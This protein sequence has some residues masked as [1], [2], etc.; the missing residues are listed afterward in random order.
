M[1]IFLVIILIICWFVVADLLLRA[2]VPPQLVTVT[3]KDEVAV[4]SS[5]NYF[6]Y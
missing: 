1:M 3:N 4:V 5:Y 2:T 6:S